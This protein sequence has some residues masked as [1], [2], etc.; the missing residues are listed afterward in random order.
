MDA[1]SEIREFLT[2]RR[3]KLTPDEVGLRSYGPRRVPGLYRNRRISAPSPM[4]AR[5]KNMQ[6]SNRVVAYSP[7]PAS[8]MV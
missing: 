8:S 2:S 4:A 5:R 3:A 6:L 7:S 1:K